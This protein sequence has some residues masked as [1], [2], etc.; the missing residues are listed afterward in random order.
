MEQLVKKPV[1]PKINKYRISESSWYQEEA[2]K[3][4]AYMREQRRHFHKHPEHVCQEKQTSEHIRAELEKIGVAWELVGDYGIL[5]VIEGKSAGNTVALRADMDALPIQELGCAPYKSINDGCMHACGHDAHMAM[6][7]GTA[8][9]LSRHRDKICGKVKLIFQQAEE[10]GAGAQMMLKGN[11]LKDCQAI[12]GLHQSAEFPTGRFFLREKDFTA[13]N[14]IFT[15]KLRGI[16][17]HGSK[18][19]LGVDPVVAAAGI[20]QA[21]QTIASRE[22]DPEDMIVVTVGYI[23]SKTSRCN[24]ITEEVELGGTVR[25]R[26]SQLLK[27]T[28]QAFFRIVEN[29]AKAYRVKPQIQY[30]NVCVPVYNDPELTAFTCQ[31]L[32]SLVGQSQVDTQAA[33]SAAEDFAFY[34]QEIPGVFCFMG[35]GDDTYNKPL[36]N[37]YYDIDERALING[38]AAY[39]K[40][41]V[42]YLMSTFAESQSG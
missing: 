20:I 25:F 14:A 28:Q 2:E 19:Q 23:N 36:H 11:A 1:H 27:K 9:I 8:K 38:A 6:L 10:I 22:T 39:S 26:N 30:E 31:V 16:G 4:F 12:F 29:T 7:L 13:A 21:L 24:I 42:D 17:S 40:L 34:Q 37:P 32:R 33:N 5:A 3:N 35:A 41:A 18:P 15:V